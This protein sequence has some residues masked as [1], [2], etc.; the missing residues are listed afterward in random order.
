MDERALLD[1]F[2]PRKEAM[3]GLLGE[4]V[5]LD[6][7]SHDKDGVDRVGRRLRDWLEEAGIACET[8]AMERHGD[9]LHARVAGGP[10]N[11]PALVM[12]HMDTVFPTG[13]AARRPFAV[14]DGR[15]HGPGCA[16]MKAGLVMN[17]FVLRAF[18]EAGGAPVPLHGLFTG[19][20]EVGSPASAPVIEAAARDA[21]AVLNSEPGRVSGNIVDGRRGGAFFRVTIRGR[22]A[23]AGLNPADGR[24]A[25]HEL[26]RKIVAWTALG[27]EAR[28]VSVNVGL[29]SGG[30]SVNTVAPDATAEIDLRFTHPEDH[31]ATAERIAAIARACEQDGVS[32]EVEALGTFHPMARTDGSLALRDAY[33][34]AA[35]ELG[36][37]TEAE[38]TRSCADSGL[39]SST[40]TPTVCALGPVGGRAHSP[41][42]Y[43]ELDTLAPRAQAMALCIARLGS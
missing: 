35:R 11:A 3:V 4:I 27:D 9:V 40:G 15:G 17:A 19:D 18:A 29:V 33:L 38:F 22:A 14:R 6:S 24:S 32:A 16:D 13:E 25:I 28:D 10:G 30:Q 21:C 5:D 7:N 43:V 41:E 20:E 12:G 37:G 8:T 36:Q 26:G 39:A 34:A 1:W 2:V 31:A 42:E 23:H